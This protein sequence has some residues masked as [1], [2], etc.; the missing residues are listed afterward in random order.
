MQEDN[1]NID[2]LVHQ[3]TTVLYLFLGISI[4]LEERS[5]VQVLVVGQGSKIARPQRIGST[6][7]GGAIDVYH[8]LQHVLPVMADS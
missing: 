3:C 4:G 5:A 7:R 2:I 8:Y 6:L 1:F